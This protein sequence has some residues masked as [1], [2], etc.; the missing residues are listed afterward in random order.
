MDVK[1]AF[2]NGKIEEEVYIEQPKGFETF[3][4]ESYVCRLK[5]EMYGMKQE[6]H[7]WYTRFNNFF[8][9]LGFT[10]SEVDANLY[11]IVVEGKLLIILLYVD[12]LILTG[13]ENLVKSCKEDLAREFEMKDLGLMHYFHGMEVWQGDE[14]LFVSQ[15]KYANDILKKFHMERNKRMETPLIG[16]W[17]KEDA[18]LGEV[19]EDTIC[20]QLVGSLM[21]L[22][23]TRSNISF[24]VNQLS[25]AMVKPR[26]LYWKVAKQC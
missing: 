22:V 15:G 17:R 5:Q 4:R 11:H 21:Y 14:E 24:A 16:N 13:D 23:N 26:K 6:P 12:D 3:D 25:Q 1:T 18:T 2:L 20:R 9:R 10:K 8:T 7:A 19:L